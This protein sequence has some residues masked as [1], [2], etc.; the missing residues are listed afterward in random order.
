LRKTS[1]SCRTSYLDALAR[2]RGETEAQAYVVLVKRTLSK[3][4]FHFRPTP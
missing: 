3:R 4:N 2:R 1:T